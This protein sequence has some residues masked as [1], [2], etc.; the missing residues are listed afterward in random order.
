MFLNRYTKKNHLDSNFLELWDKYFF[1]NMLQKKFFLGFGQAKFNKFPNAYIKEICKE[2]INSQ[3]DRFLFLHQYKVAMS[4]LVENLTLLSS[5]NNVNKNDR[6]YNIIV[7]NFRGRTKD[8][9]LFNFIHDIYKQNNIEDFLLFKQ[10]FE[11]DCKSPIYKSFINS[12][13]KRNENKGN[14]LVKTDKN[15]IEFLKVINE[16]KYTYIDFWASWCGPCRSEMPASMKLHE[17]YSSKEINFVY[18]SIDNNSLAWERAYVQI[19]LPKIKNYLLPNWSQSEIGKLFN[20][21]SIPRYVLIG[22]D[23][24][25]INADAPRPSDPKIRELFDELLKK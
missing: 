6:K 11:I 15:F 14:V 23:G 12:F 1:Y 19:G 9:L 2:G 24:K 5:D 18:I 16:K 8:Y 3:N 22:K 7:N 21:S 17:E 4:L 10:K 25:V 20:L 13:A